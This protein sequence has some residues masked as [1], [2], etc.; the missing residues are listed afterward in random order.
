[1]EAET[2]DNSH[3]AGNPSFKDHYATIKCGFNANREGKRLLW[4][5]TVVQMGLLDIRIRARLLLLLLQAWYVSP[6]RLTTSTSPDQKVNRSLRNMMLCCTARLVYGDDFL[7]G[8]QVDTD[9][10]RTKNQWSSALTSDRGSQAEHFSATWWGCS[11][12]YNLRFLIVFSI[13]LLQTSS[14][15][16]RDNLFTNIPVPARYLQFYLAPHKLTIMLSKQQWQYLMVTLMFYPTFASCKESS[17]GGASSGGSRSSG[18]TMPDFKTFVKIGGIFLAALFIFV[19][20]VVFWEPVGR[21]WNG[22]RDGN[23]NMYRTWYCN[24]AD[25][26]WN[27]RRDRNVNIHRKWYCNNA[28]QRC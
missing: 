3:L 18:W 14:Y 19:N 9:W 11:K 8:A 12:I 20:I 15:Q 25:R 17:N 7:I 5:G 10:S 2:E 23:V 6:A 26:W 13:I 16:Y 28:G 4:A 22:R 24:N 1:M 21:W 27:E